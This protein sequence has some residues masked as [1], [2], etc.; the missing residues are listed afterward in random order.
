MV[1]CLSSST[2]LSKGSSMT[3]LSDWHWHDWPFLV[4]G[5]V[6]LIRSFLI[7]LEADYT[8][9]MLFCLCCWPLSHWQCLC[10][11]HHCQSRSYNNSAVDTWLITPPWF[12]MQS[13]NGWP[14]CKFAFKIRPWWVCFCAQSKVLMTWHLHVILNVILNVILKSYPHWKDTN[15]YSPGLCGSLEPDQYCM[16]H[17][18]SWQWSARQFHGLRTLLHSATRAQG[19]IHST[20]WDHDSTWIM[21]LG[22]MVN[23][24]LKNNFIW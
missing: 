12:F 10:H 4:I 15:L 8:L 9:P 5:G 20:T 11:S 6:D 17:W 18:Q 23:L 1:S 19:K 21:V 22:C 16:H 2:L 13:C 14:L 24:S 7:C 3:S